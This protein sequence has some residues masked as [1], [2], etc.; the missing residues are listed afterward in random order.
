MRLITFTLIW[1]AGVL[2]QYY[3]DFNLPFGI[4]LLG[5]ALAFA[6]LWSSRWRLAA[7]ISF[8]A[9]MFVIGAWRFAA[10]QETTDQLVPIQNQGTVTIEGVVVREPDTRD[11]VSFLRVAVDRVLWL[12]V[13]H[14]W[15]GTVQL[16]V[17][18]SRQVDFGDRIVA[19][20]VLR[21][22]PELDEFSYSAYLARRGINSTLSPQNLQVIA[23]NQGEWW[24]GVRLSLK[25]RAEYLIERNLPEPQSSLLT[26]ILLGDDSDMPPNVEDA[27]IATGTSHIIA[28]SGFN[29]AIVAGIISGTLGRL[30]DRRGLVFWLSVLL[31]G[32][33]T[34]FVGASASVVRAALMSSVLVLGRTL[35]QHTYVPASLALVVLMMG[36]ADP[37]MLWDIGFQLSLAAVLGMML[38]VEPLEQAFQNITTAAFGWR[39]SYWL[40]Q[41]LSEALL[42]SFAAQV[43]VLP[44]ILHYFGRMSV[45]SLLAN[46]LIVPVQTYVL[47]LGGL[48]TILG[49]VWEPMGTT[50]LGAAWLP[51]VWSTFVVR[52][53]AEAPYVFIDLRISSAVLLLS[54]GVAFAMTITAATR[55]YRYRAILRQILPLLVGGTVLVI[56]LSLLAN[57]YQRQSNQPDGRLY[58]RYLDAG[59]SNSVLIETPNG[60]LFLIDGGPYPSRLLNN[61]SDM[62]PPQK[63]DIDV[64]FITNDDDEDIG[65]LTTLADRYTI[66]TVV[67]A[68]DGSR[69]QAYVDFIDDLVESGTVVLEASDGYRL[70]TTDGVVI[71]VLAPNRFMEH[72]EEMVLRLQYQT[73]VFLFTHELDPTQEQLLLQD[74]GKVQA[75][76]LQ[77]ADHG[78]PNSNSLRWITAV[79]PQVAVL[80][81]DPSDFDSEVVTPV[82]DRFAG[83]ALY[84]TD[85]HGYIEIST[86]GQTLEVETDHTDD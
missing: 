85:Y 61:I 2:L 21:P 79:N 41:T 70:E 12:G 49:L 15:Q 9:V 84:R 35:Q 31:I 6:L 83:R 64:L 37:W 80:Q 26:G 14:N 29:M 66:Q 19:T 38:L 5:S 47:L 52:G 60:G 71:D 28:I 77:V 55:P 17:P 63:R 10:V 39:S 76:V 18:R 73:A 42:V 4:L 43:F 50:V 48:G 11:T 45:L 82:I 13:W 58:V 62:T 8:G 56:T 78:R 20:G 74:V 27:F 25:Q 22:A 16:T 54:V 46:L 33:Y 34:F 86:D 3:I 24:R 40:R 32:M 75:T 51:L 23:H 53:L 44:L 72:G 1:L 59:L 36:M 30:T 7:L 57:I 67:T 69:E 81:N 68:I 65:A